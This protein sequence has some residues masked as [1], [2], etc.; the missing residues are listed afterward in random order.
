MNCAP[1][2]LVLD[3]C[4][5]VLVHY[6]QEHITLVLLAMSVAKQFSAILRS[7]KIE[8]KTYYRS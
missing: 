8:T 1:F 6:G 7:A 2:F 5:F 4:M 3:N